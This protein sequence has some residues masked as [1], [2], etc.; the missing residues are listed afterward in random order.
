MSDDVERFR[1]LQSAKQADERSWED[2]G[3]SPSDLVVAAPAG[4]WG[5]L[6]REALPLINWRLKTGVRAPA[7]ATPG[8]SSGIVEL[9]RSYVGPD[10]TRRLTART[11]AP[12]TTSPKSMQDR[13]K[14]WFLP[15]PE[16]TPLPGDV[17]GCL[18]ISSAYD[19]YPSGVLV[20]TKS[21][22]LWVAE[23]HPWHETYDYEWARGVLAQYIAG[24]P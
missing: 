13:L 11:H 7:H 12:R 2:L 23:S 4:E 1:A 14:R 18:R 15:K 20:M 5:Q 21:G 10:G 9:R 6:V 19:G 17:T 22:L 3:G 24:Q 16:P 8:W